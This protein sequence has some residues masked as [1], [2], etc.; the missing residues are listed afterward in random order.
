[1]AAGRVIGRILSLG[2]PLPG[3][4]VDNYSFLSAPSFFDYDAVVVDIGALSALIEG[5]VNGSAEATTFADQ[6]VRNDNAADRAASLAEILL[7]RRDEAAK[8]AA[9]GGVVVCFAHPETMHRG[10]SGL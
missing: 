5:V 3:P 2:F 4:Q 9:N 7:R 10:I 1:M 6:P 8:L